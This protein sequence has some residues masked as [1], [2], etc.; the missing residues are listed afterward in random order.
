MNK[1]VIAAALALVSMPAF[2]EIDPIVIVGDRNEVIASKAVQSIQVVTREQ[3]DQYGY[4]SVAEALSSIAS[5]SI[6]DTQGNGN[7]TQAAIRGFSN[8][9][10]QNVAILIDGVAVDFLTKEGGRLD[11]IN[12]GQVERIEVMNGSGGVLYGNGATAGTINVV[13]RKGTQSHNTVRATAGSFG[14]GQIELTGAVVDSEARVL[15]YSISTL[16]RDGYRYFTETKRDKANLSFETGIGS[17]SSTTRLNGS[18]ERRNTQGA[19]ELSNILADRRSGGAK[20]IYVYD[21]LGLTQTFALDSGYGVSSLVLAHQTSD[22]FTKAETYTSTNDTERD[23]LKLSHQITSADYDLLIGAEKS[24]SVYEYYGEKRSD[25]KAGFLRGT[26]FLENSRFTAGA[27]SEQTK[28]KKNG[29]RTFSNSAY[30]LGVVNDLSEHWTVKARID[31]Q[32]RTPTLDEYERTAVTDQTGA[33]FELGAV[34]KSQKWLVD[35]SAF[36]IELKDE[37]SYTY[38]PGSR[39]WDVVNIDTSDRAGA[40]ASLRHTPHAGLSYDV[41]VNLLETKFSDGEVDG[42][43]IPMSPESTLAFGITRQLSDAVSMNVRVRY[44]SEKSLYDDYG[45]LNAPIDEFVEVDI[46]GAYALTDATSLRLSAR[47]VFDNERYS[48]GVAGEAGAPA[49]VPNEGR[50][51]RATLTH[52]F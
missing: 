23:D 52:T 4:Q 41:S 28:M 17:L 19:T 49:Y 6:S 45:N 43:N 8:D 7:N 16:T 14:L 2:A 42:N 31:T 33:S 3:I 36:R 47:N 35:L 27:R 22:Q 9:S 40:Q 46:G 15:N 26:Y 51:M 37:I 18:K 44:E 30:E 12:I 29:D 13:T 10:S 48:Y 25:T 11:L 20:D 38:N 1:S 34:F 21:R 39:F 5:V 32:F 50:D 24:R